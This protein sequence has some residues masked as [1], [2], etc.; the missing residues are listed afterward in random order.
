MFLEHAWGYYLNEAGKIR[1]QG[2]F[3]FESKARHSA[4]IDGKEIT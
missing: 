3:G 4:G 1:V 2:R